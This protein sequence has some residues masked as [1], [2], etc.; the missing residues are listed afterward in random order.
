MERRREL[1]ALFAEVQASSDTIAA[2]H[3]DWPCGRGCGGCCRTLARVPDLTR[4]EWTLIEEAL[5]ELPAEEREACLQA[6]GSL[7]DQLR[8]RGEEGPCQCPLY[9][10]DGQLCRVYEARPLGCRSYGF[11]AGRSHDAWCGLVAEHVKDAREHVMTGNHD[12]LEARLTRLDSERQDLLSW[13]AERSTAKRAP[14]SVLPGA[15]IGHEAE[16]MRD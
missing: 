4:S 16:D 6:A 15:A 11:Y 3:P 2:S 8:D 13:L 1:L 9:D 12:A 10:A 14:A 5:A 7:A